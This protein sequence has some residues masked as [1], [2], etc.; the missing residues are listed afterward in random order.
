MN[1]G[2]IM[3]RKLAK[4][5]NV[6]IT[7]LPTGAMRVGFIHTLKNVNQHLCKWSEASDG[8]KKKIQTRIEIG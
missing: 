1:K 5:F 4:Y 8:D 2:K 6:R 7:I 3:K